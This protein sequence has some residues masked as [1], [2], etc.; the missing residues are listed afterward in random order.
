MERKLWNKDNRL[1]KPDFN[2]FR[3]LVDGV[4]WENNLKVQR[5]GELPVT[6]RDY[7]TCTIAGYPHAK[8]R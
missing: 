5:R 8:G 3:K 2:K 4:S 7:I 6:E 1:Q